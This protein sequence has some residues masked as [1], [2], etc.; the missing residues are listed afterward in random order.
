M[1]IKYIIL[2]MMMTLEI[3]LSYFFRADTYF[4]PLFTYLYTMH[5]T[6][7]EEKQTYKFSFIA[8]LLYDTLM[9][10][11]FLN[12][13]L[14]PM[15]AFLLKQIE[16]RMDQNKIT[17]LI[18]FFLLIFFYRF[19]TYLVLIVIQYLEFSML[20][21][22]RSILSSIFLNF[23]FLLLLQKITLYNQRKNHSFKMSKT[24]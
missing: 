2:I 21:F 11:F 5:E 22:L 24:T 19:F 3:A 1:R 8:G 9:N 20:R 23:L 16:K 15:I 10:T 17:F 6:R 12:A 7:K 13:F 4:L 14:F 18:E